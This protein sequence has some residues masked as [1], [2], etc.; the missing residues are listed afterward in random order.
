M[1]K[2][3]KIL[4]GAGV[5]ALVLGGAG[6]GIA[7]ADTSSPAPQPSTPAPAKHK[8]ALLG[9]VAHGEFTLNGKK[10]QVI[11]VQRGQVQSVGP[12]A[13]TVRSNDG[14]TATYTV[15]SGTKVKK[16]KQ[17]SAIGQ[18]AVNDHVFVLADKSGSTVTAKRINDSGAPK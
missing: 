11:D 5:T 18:V 10:H 13:I 8:K 15:D 2:K 1:R 16:A 12:D 9:R 7:L 3:T 17:A 6:S 4:I 14:F